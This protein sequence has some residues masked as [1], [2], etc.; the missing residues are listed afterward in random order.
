ATGNAY[1][2]GGRG[3]GGGGGGGGGDAGASSNSVY[4]PYYR[5]SSGSVGANGFAG[6]RDNSALTG[7]NIAAIPWTDS[8]N[9]TYWAAWTP[10]SNTVTNNIASTTIST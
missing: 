9:K 10:R 1:G 8:G 5:N 6:W 7:S 4:P 3:G 2:A